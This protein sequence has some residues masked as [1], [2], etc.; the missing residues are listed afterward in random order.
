MLRMEMEMTTEK[1]I[2]V[3][4]TVWVRFE[5]MVTE[6]TLQEEMNSIK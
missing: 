1:N 6:K 3:S 4:T 5:D 2:I